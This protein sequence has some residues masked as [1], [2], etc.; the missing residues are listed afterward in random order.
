MRIVLAQINPIIG[1]LDGNEKKIIQAIE[2]AKSLMAD[3]VLFPELSLIG[4]PPDDLLLEDEFISSVEKKLLLIARETK[5]IIAV[6]GT[7][8]RNVAPFGKPLFNTAAILSDQKI[9]GFQDKILLPTYDV[10]DE[11]RYFEPGMMIKIFDFNGKK[12]AITICEDIWED[13]GSDFF[14]SRYHV[15]PI[16]E[17]KKLNPDLV[18]NLSASPYSK[19]HFKKRRNACSYAAIQANA[20]LLYCNQVGAN[21]SL[22]F[23]GHSLFFEKDGELMDIAKGFK[24]DFFVVDYP[25]KLLPKKLENNQLFDIWRALVLGVRDYFQ[26]MGFKKAILGLSGGIDSALV[27]CIAKDALGEENLLC[28]GM[29]SRFSSLKSVEEAKELAENLNCKFLEIPIEEPFK[30]YLDLLDSH[31]KEKPFDITE[32]NLQARIR[33]MILMAFSN[34]F[35]HLLLNTGNKSELALGY[36]TLYGDMCGALSVI[37]DVTKSEVYE[38]AKW[39]NKDKEIIPWNTIYKAPSAELRDNQKDQ[40]SLPEYALIDQVLISHLEDGMSAKTIASQF[41]FQI[42]IVEDLIKRIYQNEYKRRQAPLAIRISKKALIAGRK[43]PI[44]QKWYDIK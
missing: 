24:E 6:V 19:G 8:R 37:G 13:Q 16:S 17:L 1:D 27:A 35:G 11:S 10:F 32:E 42:E 21:D 15:S 30:T 44:V 22:V 14:G 40:D 4:Y 39:V 5:G 36:C 2:E 25:T 12:T 23:D 38:L 33:G 43:V 26:K 18:L 20:P 9:V 34:K 29:P 41:N 31:F 28:I 3:L 7:I